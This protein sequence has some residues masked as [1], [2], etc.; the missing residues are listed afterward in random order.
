M[1]AADTRPAY[2]LVVTP[3]MVCEAP[4]RIVVQLGYDSEG[5]G[6]TSDTSAPYVRSVF[7]VGMS[8]RDTSS[9][10]PSTITRTTLC[11]S[12]AAGVVFRDLRLGGTSRDT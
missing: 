11:D 2:Q 10:I 6:A 1:L 7:S 9:R 12:A 4:V 8:V 3:L 5:C